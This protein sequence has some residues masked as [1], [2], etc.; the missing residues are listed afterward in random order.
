MRALKRALREQDAIVGEDADGHAVD[1]QPEA[2]E[3][4]QA[5]GVTVESHIRPGLGHSIDAEGIQIAC[6][7]LKK[8]FA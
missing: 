8:I 5:A 1:Q 3:K 2:I 4:L 7:F 6:D